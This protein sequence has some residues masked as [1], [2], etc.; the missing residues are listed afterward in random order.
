MLA[1]HLKGLVDTERG[2]VLRLLR[3]AGLF[4]Q[5]LIENIQYL[6]LPTRLGRGRTSRLLGQE[7]YAFGT[8]LGL[9][10]GLQVL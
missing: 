7:P 1:L 5:L 4:R 10:E 3:V 2:V 8:P 6:V 9:L